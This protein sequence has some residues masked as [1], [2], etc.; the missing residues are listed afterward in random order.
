M[1]TNSFLLT[2]WVECN[3]RD[4]LVLECVCDLFTAVTDTI[5]PNARERCHCT[6]LQITDRI[7]EPKIHVQRILTP[8][9]VFG[10]FVGNRFRL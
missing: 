2:A 10:V 4:N 9:S 1:C 3:V 5:H 7:S 6:F 8:C